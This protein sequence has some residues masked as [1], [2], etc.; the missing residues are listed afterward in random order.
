MTTFLFFVFEKNRPPAPHFLEKSWLRDFSFSFDKEFVFWNFCGSRNTFRFLEFLRLPE[1]FS[2]T[3]ITP[4]G[5]TITKVASPLWGFWKNRGQPPKASA[6]GYLFLA[7]AEMA[8]GGW[9]G[10]WLFSCWKGFVFWPPRSFQTLL[11]ANSGPLQKKTP[12]QT[13]S[14]LP[15][16]IIFSSHIYL[17]FGFSRSSFFFLR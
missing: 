9:K 3:K 5:W 17:W 10:D 15:K 6:E 8:Q 12:R 2:A 4:R 13:N 7:P 1:Y 14:S 11:L 16:T